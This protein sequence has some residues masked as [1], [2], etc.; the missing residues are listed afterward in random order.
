LR[1]Y[2]ERTRNGLVGVYLPNYRNKYFRI[3]DNIHS[4]Y[5]VSI[6]W[7]DIDK[8]FIDAIHK[9]WNN[10]NRPELIEN[11]RK[12]REK[13]APLERK[14]NSNRQNNNDCFI[15]T[16]AYGT[17]FAKEVLIMKRWRDN[18]VNK[19]YY[20]RKCIKYYYKYSP[21]MANYIRNKPNFKRLIRV[22]IKIITKI[23]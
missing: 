14:E 16:A 12:V 9:A 1:P 10:R 4:G 2:G 20:G 17:P 13:N 11:T 8:S 6:H 18:K 3:T 19:S 22:L 7:K 23:I 15:A 21:P 5:A